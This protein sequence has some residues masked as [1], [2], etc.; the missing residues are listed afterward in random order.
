MGYQKNYKVKN[1]QGSS[2]ILQVLLIGYK[3]EI[4]MLRTSLEQSVI[5]SNT[6]H[7]E[8]T[9]SGV[10]W[11]VTS[12]IYLKKQDIKCPFSPFI[13]IFGSVAQPEKMILNSEK[14]SF[15]SWK[16]NSMHEKLLHSCHAEFS[17]LSRL[18]HLVSGAITTPTNSNFKFGMSYTCKGQLLK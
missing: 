8:T 4:N 9:T 15:Y 18:N 7:H 3:W 12:K 16:G 13:N 10:S 11:Q 5:K 2:S 6:S 17:F 14:G 1:Y